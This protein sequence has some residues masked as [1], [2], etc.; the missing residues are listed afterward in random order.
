MR[1]R[2]QPQNWHLASRNVPVKVWT[3][4][5]SSVLGTCPT[6]GL[7]DAERDRA[8]RFRCEEDSRRFCASRL[9]LREV[10]GRHLG[11]SP[12]DLQ[13]V[14]APGGKLS[15]VLPPGFPPVFFSLSRSGDF[16]AVALA[17]SAEVGVDIEKT[18]VFPGWPA[19]AQ[20]W[21]SEGEK[22]AIRALAGEKSRTE[23]FF[24][25]WCA[26]EAAAKALGLGL[27]LDPRSAGSLEGLLEGGPVVAVFGERTV[28]V[29][30]VEA[31]QGYRLAVASLA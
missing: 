5:V 21:L 1:N 24:R 7:S 18:R 17:S 2:L 20:A 27:S 14:K 9:L 28:E 6:A 30:E 4:S 31:P 25:L 10:L 8:G 19:V 15:V 16:C 11:T 26:R 22:N 23:A 12:G 13:L 3:V 29:A